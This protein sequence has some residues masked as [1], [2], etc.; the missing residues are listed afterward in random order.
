[1]LTYF[2]NI[3]LYQYSLKQFRETSVDDEV[4]GS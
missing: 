1:M 4:Q 3:Y 2:H